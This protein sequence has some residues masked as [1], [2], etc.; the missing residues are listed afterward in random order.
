[1]ID[2]R[3]ITKTDD[4][5]DSPEYEKITGHLRGGQWQEAAGLIVYLLNSHPGDKALESLLA[6][7]Q[8][9]L[10]T[11]RQQQT[12]S[13][14]LRLPDRRVV[15][16]ITL[17]A[18]LLGLVW[19]AQTF[20]RDFMS[21]SMAA[22]QTAKANDALAAEAHQALAAADYTRARE[23]YTQ[24][25]T[26]N[27]NYPGL[28]EGLSQAKQAMS[29]EAKYNLAQQQLADDQLTE[30]Q[31]TLTSIQQIQ[32]TY[33]DIG[34]LL[35]KIERR[36]RLT[37]LLRQANEARD[38]KDWDATVSHLEEARLISPQE[39]LDAITAD[40]FDAYLVL[41]SQLISTSQ[42][43]TPEVT[44][45]VEIYNKA[46]ALRPQERQATNMRGWANAY[47]AGANAFAGGDWDTVIAQ[48]EPL[49]ADQPGYVGGKAVQV[50]YDAY[51]RSGEKLRE[52]NP[53][54]A[55][56]RYYKASQLKGVDATT[57]VALAQEL[58]RYM[59]PTPL[60]KPTATPRPAAIAQAGP[61]RG[62]PP[63]PATAPP[64][65]PEPSYI[66]KILYESNRGGAPEMWV[67]DPDGKN[68][69]HLDDQ[70]KARANYQRQRAADM[71]SPDGQGTVAAQQAPGD[72]HQQI[73]IVYSNGNT[74]RVT[75]LG[76][77]NYDP[78]WSPAGQWIAFTSNYLG[79][80]DIFVVGVN[81]E[82]LRRMTVNTWEWDKH[83]S[84]SS[85]GKRLVFWS[86]R[87]S[88]HAQIW[89][90]NADGSGQVNISNTEFDEKDPVWLK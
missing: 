77:V 62:S 89:L 53:A 31:A 42:G 46:L 3:R 26:A 40:L 87:G 74:T 80:D 12:Q 7:T 58:S 45:A 19:L 69:I 30:A 55:W 51:M 60:P 6:E 4:W 29:L 79:N 8:L 37:G 18:V 32:P 36:Q 39:D 41:G 63:A 81:G 25:A 61:P 49:Y 84:W 22:A 20:Y 54:L 90:M 16:A 52:D 88:G 14:R 71:R 28:A 78:V 72:E 24:L 59:T 1:M 68:Q 73:Y 44:H 10:D 5:R 38:A 15:L 64:P 66:G 33:R 50:L 23:L 56:E 34:T 82:G 27:P 13:R 9:R 75:A 86:N 35:A 2:Q 85:D 17:V 21:P 57:A 83:P 11:E 65:T 47:L 48:L 76:G 67:M 43:R 70:A